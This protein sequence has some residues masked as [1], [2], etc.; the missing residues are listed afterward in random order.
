MKY[1]FDLDNTLTESRSVITPAMAQALIQ[2]RELGNDIIVVSGAAMSQIDFQ[3]GNG[4]TK[5]PWTYMAQNGNHVVYNSEELWNN[6]LDADI[7]VAIYEHIGKVMSLA[8][9]ALPWGRALQDLIEDR[10]SQISFSFV[11]H[12]APLKDKKQFDPTGSLRKIV[13]DIVE[14]KL[15]D[16]SVVE[17]RRFEVRVA[18]TTCLDYFKK[19]SNKGHNIK[20]LIRA[21]DWKESEC[22][23]VGDALFP[24]GNDESVIGVISTVQVSSPD[25]TL[26][27]I[28]KQVEGLST[29]S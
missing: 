1:F 10:G 13:L 2:L 24:G 23:Y 12:Y 6:K 15:E 29:K 5:R 4:E 22:V 8:R 19:G 21:R 16:N 18:G 9:I 26:S 14:K 7:K 3:V 25:D 17:Q 11:G 28:M 20:A 27:F